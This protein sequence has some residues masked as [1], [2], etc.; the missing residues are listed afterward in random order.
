MRNR[1][2]DFVIEMFGDDPRCNR[3]TV[4]RI[5]RMSSHMLFLSLSHFLGKR[6]SCPRRCRLR[7]V[8]SASRRSRALACTRGKDNREFVFLSP[9]RSLKTLPGPLAQSVTPLYA[10]TDAVR[11]DA[12]R[13]LQCQRLICLCAIDIVKWPD[14]KHGPAKF[15]RD[16]RRHR[17]PKICRAKIDG[18][19]RSLPCCIRVKTPGTSG[20][21]LETRM[22]RVQTAV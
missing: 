1:L 10:A 4:V 18:G 19:A 21:F 5:V 9:G 7:I 8:V 6:G 22:S 17:F 3:M 16:A 15:A 2:R 11:S 20:F 14:D 12:S 13:C